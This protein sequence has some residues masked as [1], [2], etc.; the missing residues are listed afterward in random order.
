MNIVLI[1]MFEGYAFYKHHSHIQNRTAV[2]Y[3]STRFFTKIS[4]FE[5]FSPKKL[6]KKRV[7]ILNIFSKIRLPYFVKSA[8]QRSLS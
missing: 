2:S 5:L 3:A 8:R 1:Y 6:N 7:A 4:I